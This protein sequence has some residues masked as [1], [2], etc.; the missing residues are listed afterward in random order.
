MHEVSG[1]NQDFW[2]GNMD[3]LAFAWVK[4]HIP[5][6]SPNAEE[7]PSRTEVPDYLACWWLSGKRQ[8]H[9]QITWPGTECFQVGH[10]CTIERGAG[11]IL[12][13]EV[14]QRSLWPPQMTPRQV[15]QFE[16]FLSGM[17]ESNLKCY[18]LHQNKRVYIRVSNDL[19]VEGFAKI[20]KY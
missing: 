14:H 11:P 10:W 12:S 19:F 8:Y 5:D 4:L 6:L 18:L 3:Y 7:T 17:T 20:Q 15:L 9:Q 2:A 1:L 16:C 13:P